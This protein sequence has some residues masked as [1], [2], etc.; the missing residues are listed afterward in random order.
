[1]KKILFIFTTF[2]LLVGCEMSSTNYKENN[3]NNINKEEGENS[4]Y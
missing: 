2:F 1:M 4:N 3:N